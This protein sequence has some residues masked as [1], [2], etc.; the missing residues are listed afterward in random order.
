MQLITSTDNPK[1]KFLK[2]LT[3]PKGRT[4]SGLCLVEGQKIIWEN[5]ELVEQ[6]ILRDDIQVTP[7]LADMELIVLSQKLFNQISDIDSPCGMMATVRIPQNQPTWTYPMLVLDRIADP[8]NVG[9]IL[10]SAAAFG[11]DSVVA[12]NCAGIYSQKVIRAAMGHQFK[13]KNTVIIS[14]DNFFNSIDQ[15]G[16]PTFLLA[17]LDGTSIKELNNKISGDFALVL[18]NEGDGPD[19]RFRKLNHQVITIPMST[20]TESLNVA[21]AGGIIMYFLEIIK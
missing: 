12:I 14:S 21:V 7:N 15:F 5:L 13:L 20:K 8:G 18:G 4:N 19:P 6:I 17:D 2:T 10:R 11:Y 3:T 1:F 9:T 16:N